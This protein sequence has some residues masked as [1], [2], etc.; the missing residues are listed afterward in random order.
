MPA[1]P[2]ARSLGT[3]RELYS[4]PPDLTRRAQ[5]TCRR[6]C[7]RTRPDAARRARCRGARPS[8]EPL[9]HLRCCAARAKGALLLCRA[10]RAN[11]ACTP[12]SRCACT[13]HPQRARRGRPP[14]VIHAPCVARLHTCACDHAQKVCGPRVQPPRRRTCAI[15]LTLRICRL[16]ISRVACVAPVPLI[17]LQLHLVSH[18]YLDRAS[19]GCSALFPFR[20]KSPDE[21]PDLHLERPWLGCAFRDD[22]RKRIATYFAHGSP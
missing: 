12:A 16:L 4:A 3:R 7:G 8:D 5:L 21:S 18:C 22:H 10:A 11:D 20:R 15:H 17:T 6:P 13:R 14:R 1:P 2:R 9:G 19:C